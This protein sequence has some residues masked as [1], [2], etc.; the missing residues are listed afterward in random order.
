MLIGRVEIHR[1]ISSDYTWKS[2]ALNRSH[3]RRRRRRE[4]YE[5]ELTH[6]RSS[7]RED[8]KG[9]FNSTRRANE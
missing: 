8:L 4:K 5:T 1:A 6:E 3:S 9:K 7:Q 2:R